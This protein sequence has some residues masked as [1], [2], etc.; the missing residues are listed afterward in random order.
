M[1]LFSHLG[2]C[3]GIPLLFPDEQLPD[4]LDTRI[5]PCDLAYQLVPHLGEERSDDHTHRLEPFSPGTVREQF[6]EDDRHQENVDGQE[7]QGIE[8][9]VGG[10]LGIFQKDQLE[11][12]DT[13]AH[14]DQHD[15]QFSLP[16]D[17][18]VTPL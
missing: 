3:S 16:I 8:D 5:S 10:V 18:R 13:E 17:P 7:S 1:H 15:R 4:T 14:G 11:R 9:V 6:V 2:V 12:I